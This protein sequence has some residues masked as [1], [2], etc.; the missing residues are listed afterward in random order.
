MPVVFKIASGKTIFGLWKI[1]ESIDVLTELY[2]RDNYEVIVP[3][4]LCG[5]QRRAEWLASRLLANEMLDRDVTVINDKSGKPFIKD[6]PLFISISHTKGY[7]AVVISDNNIGVDIELRNRSAIAVRKRFMNVVEIESANG[8]DDNLHALLHWSAK[9]ALFK[10]VGN[11]GGNFRDNITTLPFEQAR[12]GVIML[13]LH[14][15]KE[16]YEGTYLVKY[17]IG[18][19]LLLTLCGENSLDIKQLVNLI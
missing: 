13:R 8:C 14:D 12:V 2:C 17:L 11:L 6:V 10:V 19:E 16:G 15:V 18:D 5:E 9:E 3:E 7:A 4:E 1:T